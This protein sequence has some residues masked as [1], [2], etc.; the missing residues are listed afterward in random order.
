M[1][2]EGD[3]VVR[4]G[5]RA[6][7]VLGLSVLLMGSKLVISV[8]EGGSVTSSSGLFAC[9]A[10]ETCTIDIDKA[11]FDETFSAQAAP[12][13]L[14]SRWGEHAGA[15]CAGSH[16]A[17]CDALDKGPFSSGGAGLASLE[18][19]HSL[20]PLFAGHS[21]D[22]HDSEVDISVRSYQATRYYSVSGRDHKEIWH[23][24]TGP[25]NPNPVDHFTGRKPLGLAIFRYTYSYQS[26]FVQG[27]TL[28]RVQQAQF[29]LRFETVLPTLAV[30]EKTRRS[31]NTRWT[32]LAQNITEHEAGHH[33]INRQLVTQL[34]AALRSIGPMACHGLDR[35]VKQ[36]VTDAVAKVE[37]ANRDYDRHHSE[38]TYAI[39]SL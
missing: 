21:F 12:G 29:D 3:D 26:E 24:L 38:E 22:R 37:R 23:Q 2:T 28:C 33:E 5:L 18:Q 31:L 35:R 10:G 16:D 14:F 17:H 1:E 19:A 8:P 27:G 36:A 6:A 15:L 32:D 39:T 20:M 7:I 4:T 13:Y 34:P 25:A 11:H 30:D 9:H